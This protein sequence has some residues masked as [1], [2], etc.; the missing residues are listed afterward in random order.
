MLIENDINSIKENKKEIE[1][2]KWIS[3]ESINSIIELMNLQF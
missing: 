2:V 3:K 1:E